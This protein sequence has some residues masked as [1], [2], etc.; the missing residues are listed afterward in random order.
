[1]IQQGFLVSQNDSPFS[2]LNYYKPAPTVWRG[3]SRQSG[4]NGK[5]RVHQLR[6]GPSPL[7]DAQCLCWRRAEGFMG[8][9]KVAMRDIQRDCRNVIVQFLAEAVR[10]S[11]EPAR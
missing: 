8:A 5:R 3:L 7:S 6:D 9:A 2:S 11:R 10:Q 4:R 1:L